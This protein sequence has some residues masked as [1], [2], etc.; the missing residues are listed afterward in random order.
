MKRKRKSA[1]S[2]SEVK[3]LLRAENWE[4]SVLN[5]PVDEAMKDVLLAAGGQTEG[6]MELARANRNL[7]RL[8]MGLLRLAEEGNKNAATLLL[9]NLDSAVLA[10]NK[11]AVSNPGVFL[12]YTEKAVAIPIS[13][14]PDPELKKAGLSLLKKLRVGDKWPVAFKAHEG[15]GRRWRPRNPATRLAVSLMRKI[16]LL[17]WHYYLNT[18]S[19]R[20]LR[21]EKASWLHRA[22]SLRDFSKTTWRSWAATAWEI[23][24]D[25]SPHRSPKEHPFFKRNKAW[26]IRTKR[27]SPYPTR[28]DE[29]IVHSSPSIARNDI[30]EALEGAFEL[31]A[32]GQTAR[33]R[34]RKTRTQCPPK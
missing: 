1:P 20:K 18:P 31:L 12:P 22:L 7:R 3:R 2:Q 5:L 34:Q 21:L 14:S 15:P 13:L 30:K 29:D 9:R 26:K 19:S 24:E 23:L 4:R 17:R 10:F 25:D 32:T 27:L 33:T 8:W 28:E 11:L 16:Y 6:M